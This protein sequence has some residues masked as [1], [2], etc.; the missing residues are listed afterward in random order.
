MTI[1]DVLAAVGGL[2]ALC[3]CTWALYLTIA[4]LFQQRANQAAD[5]AASG[6]WKSGF[7]G[8]GIALI[9]IPFSAIV[10]A[11]P[12]GRL[13]AMLAI[14]TMLTFSVIGGAGISLLAARRIRALDPSINPFSALSRGAALVVLPSLLPVLGWFLVGPLLFFVGLGAGVRAL[15]ASATQSTT[16]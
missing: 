4:L 5:A 9:G 14:L 12:G 10:W 1:G 6:P 13:F 15:I 7:A 8:F 3:V 11:L 2:V 16:A